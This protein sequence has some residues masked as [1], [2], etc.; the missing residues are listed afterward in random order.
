ME[1]RDTTTTDAF[2]RSLHEDG[3]GW[4]LHIAGRGSVPLPVPDWTCERRPGDD[5]LLALCAG[6]VL[7]VGCGPGRLT[8]ALHRAGRSALGIDVA[9]VAV[10]L[11]RARG[12]EALELDVFGAVPDTGAWGTLLLADGNIGIGGDPVALLHRC[13]R[14]AAPGGRVVVELSAPGVPSRTHLVRLERAGEAPGSGWFPW[15]TLSAADVGE[16]AGAAG[17]HAAGPFRCTAGRWFASLAVPQHVPDRRSPR[18]TVGA[19]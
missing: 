16:V 18:S 5:A 1:L 10:S 9:P 12:A 3:R 17:L 2:G 8:A 11:A 13:A 15:A 7:D 6:T 14:L 4:S 19:A